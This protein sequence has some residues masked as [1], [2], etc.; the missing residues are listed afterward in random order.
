MKLTKVQ[1]TLLPSGFNVIVNNKSYKTYYP[2]TVWTSFPIGLRQ[3]LANSAAYF[4]TRHFPLFRRQRIEYAFPPPITQSFFLHGLLYSLPEIVLKN[5]EYHHTVSSL[6]KTVLNSG[7]DI[8]FSGNPQT[9]LYP[10]PQNTH[11]KKAVQLFSFGKDSLLT[12]ALTKELG[13]TPVPFFFKEPYSNIEISNKE[14]LK[15]DFE[16]WEKIKIHFLPNALGKLRQDGKEMWGWDMLLSQY[17]L[18]LIPY[19]LNENA[20]YYFLSNEQSTNELVYDGEDFLVN[21]TFEQSVDWTVHLNN[22][23]QIFSIATRVTS[24]IEPLQE[25]V[26]MYILHHRYPEIGKYQL[27]CDNDHISART[28]RW[29]ENCFECARVYLFL[30][31][32]GI[33]PQSIGFTGNMLVKEK[34]D[35]FL[36]FSKKEKE[37]EKETFINKHAERILAFYLTHLRNISGEVVE[38]FRQEL[39]PLI[40]PYKQMLFNKYFKIYKDRGI[41]RELRNKTL[42]IYQDELKAFK[43]EINAYL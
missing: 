37:L 7:Y 42:S 23:L 13:L 21:V 3:L 2:K 9:S 35:H 43:S 8:Q 5:P 11:N 24:I 29:C 36:L 26:I 14:K 12:Y 27:S 31:A 17:T 22:L 32:V 34:I 6:V 25:L 28:R 10:L 18:L 40:L 41:P 39:L 30:C 4:F 16:N 19:L 33:D 15:R 1:T 20:Q 38:I